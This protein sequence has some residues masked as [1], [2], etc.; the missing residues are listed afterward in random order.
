MNETFKP[1]EQ[2]LVRGNDTEEWVCGIYSHYDSVLN[3]H[4]V[5]GVFYN[6]CIPYED[7]KALLGTKDSPQPKRWRANRGEYY[8]YIDS[9]EVCLGQ[10]DDV[11][12]NDKRYNIGNYFR[13]REE[14]EEMAVKFR[15]LLVKAM[16]KGE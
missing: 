7:N 15:A 14:A 2:V 8:W 10:E 3:S 11:S 5:M 16:L 1:F 9:F 6:E 12:Y 13:S 4:C